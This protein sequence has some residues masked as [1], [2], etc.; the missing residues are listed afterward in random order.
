M[1]VFPKIIGITGGIGGGKSTFSSI[2]RQKNFLVYDS[3]A[4]AKKLQNEHEGVRRKITEAFGTGIYNEMGLDRKRL[5]DCVFHDKKALQTLNKI[6]H[7]AVKE[8]FR[9]WCEAHK[10]EKLLFIEAAVL[11]EGNFDKLVDLVVLVTANEEERIKRVMNR[12]NISRESVLSRISNQYSESLKEKKSDFVIYT[13]DN[14]D[15]AKKIGFL[16]KKLLNS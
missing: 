13:D 2:L 6:V 14:I 1:D 4:E 15:L 9:L 5:A 10:T 12:D 3:D 16:L 11:F 8:D 7:P